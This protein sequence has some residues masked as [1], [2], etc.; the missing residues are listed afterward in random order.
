MMGKVFSVSKFY[1][2]G[3]NLTKISKRPKK[4]NKNYLFS[5]KWIE[6]WNHIS[7]VQNWL[8]SLINQGALLQ[9][10]WQKLSREEKQNMH[11][12]LFSFIVITIYPTR[13]IISKCP[14]ELNKNYLFSFKW[15][16]F[17]NHISKVQNWQ[18]TLINQGAL[19]QGRWQKLSREEKQNMHMLLFHL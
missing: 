8:T 18:T 11:M 16:E 7:K 10:R 12:L 1:K 4:L 19:L 6:F 5:F 15:I 9:G 14:K 13:H 17:W 3:I 2:K